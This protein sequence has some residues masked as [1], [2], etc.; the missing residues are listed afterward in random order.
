M[1]KV[2]WLDRDRKSA[3]VTLGTYRVML[4]GVWET[5]S[6]GASRVEISSWE[7]LVGQDLAGNYSWRD[8][9]QLP[10]SNYMLM[11]ALPYFAPRVAR[12]LGV[13]K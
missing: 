7:I 4:T 1:I 10:M 9:D 2:R 5:T 11:L 12:R 8:T 6:Y 3:L 13:T